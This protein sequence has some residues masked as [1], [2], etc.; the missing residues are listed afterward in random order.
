MMHGLMSKKKGAVLSAV[1]IPSVT[2]PT[3]YNYVQNIPPFIAAASED[4]PF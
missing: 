2:W 1:C 4:T 3:S